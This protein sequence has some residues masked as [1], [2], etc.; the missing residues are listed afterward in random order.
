[1]LTLT[2][3]QQ[4]LDE[5]VQQTTP[6]N[7][8][9][10]DAVDCR[11]SDDIIAPFDSPPFDNSAMDGIALSDADLVGNPPWTLPVSEII[12]AGHTPN[13]T[14]PQGY[15]VK[16]MTGAPLPKGANSVIPV[17]GLEFSNRN[18]QIS[19]KPI[20]GKHIRP[21]G[22]DFKQGDVLINAGATIKVV[23]VGVLTSI[24]LREVNV[25]PKPTV[26]ILSTGS[27]IV[28][29]GTKLRPGQI[30]DLNEPAL[31]ALLRYKNH[32]NVSVLPAVKDD[33]ARMTE[34]L[35]TAIATHRI[36]IT[37]GSVSMGD[38]DFLPQVVS[39]LGGK[40]VFHKVMVKPG[41]PV[42]FAEF[43]DTDKHYLI[44]L[45]GNPVSVIVGYHLWVKRLLARLMGHSFKPETVSAKLTSTVNIKGARLNI[46]G[47]TIE[48]DGAEILA[49]SATRQISGHIGSIRGID[50]FIYVDPEKPMPVAGNVVRV[51]ML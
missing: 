12:E 42:I 8:G 44:G 17:E 5:T 25:I 21:R 11:L 18:V 27:E 19:S 34:V 10:L 1:M 30:Y 33:F 9:I 48:K 24:G 47:V 16:I 15:A 2:Q 45:P 3:A 29:A 39:A 7:V 38:F 43:G 13:W 36:V 40:I 31:I 41:K 49:H 4:L 46:I 26:A 23:D 32:I 6:T 50:G 51:E 14:L 28:S 20:P 22:G 37:S 35:S